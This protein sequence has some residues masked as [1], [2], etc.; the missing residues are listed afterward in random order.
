MQLYGMAGFAEG[1]WAQMISELWLGTILVAVLALVALGRRSRNLAIAALLLDGVVALVYAPWEAFSAASND[2]TDWQSLLRAWQ[3]AA[4][5]WVGVSIAAGMVTVW[6]LAWSSRHHR[7][8]PNAEPNQPLP[9][10]GA[11]CSLLGLPSY[12]SDPSR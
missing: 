9:P 4:S 10:T 6:L 11:A 8:T 2:D 3:T 1:A 12:P 7:K 5:F